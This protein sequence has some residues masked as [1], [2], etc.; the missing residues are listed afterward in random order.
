M[1]SDHHVRSGDVYGRY[2][3]IGRDRPRPEPNR[4]NKSVE[5]FVSEQG[6]LLKRYIKTPLG[7]KEALELSAEMLRRHRGN[8]SQS[9][10]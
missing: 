2:N 10:T 9:T 6:D 4:S 7:S 5:Q 3:G 8:H 1:S